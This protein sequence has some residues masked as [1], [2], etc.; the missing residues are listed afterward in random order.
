MNYDMK[1]PIRLNLRL[2]Q[3][4]HEQTSKAAFKLNISQAQFI[5]LALESQLNKS[6][7]T[8]QDE[9]HSREL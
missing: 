5:R 4:L 8:I 9:F 2:D 7:K 3:E 6:L 1:Y